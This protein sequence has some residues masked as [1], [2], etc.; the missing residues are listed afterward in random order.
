MTTCSAGSPAS[1]A[2]HAGGQAARSGASGASPAPPPSWP[3][4]SA[5]CLRLETG[6]ARGGIAARAGTSAFEVHD[7]KRRM[8]SAA[9]FRDRVVH[10]ALHAWSGR[11]S[12]AASSTTAMPTASAKAPTA[13]VA[14]YERFR[15][16][17][18]HVLRCDIFRYLSGDR[19]R[20]PER[21][22]AAPIECSRTLWLFDTIIDGSNPQEPVERTIRATTC[23]TPFVAAAACRSAT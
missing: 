7:P 16:R 18:R 20:D 14:R 12:S 22:S 10:H 6:A 1:G 23:S 2:L 8:V 9:P 17:Y 21:R 3:V 11:S 19:P 15:D 13:A 4:S 5:S